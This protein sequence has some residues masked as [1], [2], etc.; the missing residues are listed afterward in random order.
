MKQ[1][2]IENKK[3]IPRRR[4]RCAEDNDRNKQKKPGDQFHKTEFK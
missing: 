2:G 3:G 4:K 1:Q